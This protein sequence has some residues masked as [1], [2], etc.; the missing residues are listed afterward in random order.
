MS[1]DFNSW[2]NGPSHQKAPKPSY[3]YLREK[4]A[5]KMRIIGEILFLAAIAFLILMWRFGWKF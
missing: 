3:D 1:G 2:D 4:R 5:R